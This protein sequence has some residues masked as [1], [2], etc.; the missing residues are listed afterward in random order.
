MYERDT[1]ILTRQGWTSLHYTVNT[2]LTRT[3]PLRMDPALAQKPEH[4]RALSHVIAGLAG[5][6]GAGAVG[7]EFGLAAGG[8]VA[9]S[10]VAQVPVGELPFS[11]THKIL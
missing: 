8:G 9:V 6:L 3:P 11:Y 2:V 4:R 7:G 10:H 1:R 5:E